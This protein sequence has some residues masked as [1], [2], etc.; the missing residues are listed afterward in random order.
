MPRASRF[1]LRTGVVYLVITFVAG[2]VLLVLEAIGYPVPPVIWTEHGHAGF[3]GW[4][5]NT[6]IGVA[7]WLL[8]LNRQ[9]FPESQGRYPER[10]ALAAFYLLNVGLVMRLLCEPWFAFGHSVTAS[11]LLAIAAVLQV[12]GIVIVAWILWQRIFAPPLRPEV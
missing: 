12:G 6:V 7:L 9:R 8:P 4:L 3:V 5:V 2:A 1:F 11:V 10:L